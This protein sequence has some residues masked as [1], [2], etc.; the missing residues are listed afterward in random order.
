MSANYTIFTDSGCDLPKELLEE[1]GVPCECLTYRFNDSEEEFKDRSKPMAEFYEKMRKKGVAKTAAVTPE[2]F[3]AAFSKVL[4]AGTDVLYLGFSSG[5]SNT[6]NA[7]R[8]ATEQLRIKYPERKIIAVDTLCASAGLALI[9]KLV[10]EKKEAGAT[11]EE[12]AQYAENIK[13]KICHWYTVDDLVYLKRGGRVSPMLAFAAAVTGIK[14]IMNMNNEGKLISISKVRGRRN[15]IQA[16]AQKYKEEAETPGTGHIFISHG[17]CEEEAKQL[18]D[19]I[20]QETG[21]TVDLITEIG[22]VIGAHA[23]PGTIA[24]FFVGRNR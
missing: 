2:A 11:I 17:D 23:G 7:G 5:I 21:A 19:L 14:P 16:L 8:I 10:L 9:L 18:A 3:T 24:L 4:E 15:A 20:H 1:W 6:Y 12:A 13:L 22:A